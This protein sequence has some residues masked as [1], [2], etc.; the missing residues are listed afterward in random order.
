MKSSLGQNKVVGIVKKRYCKLPNQ[1]R[2]NFGKTKRERVLRGFDMRG[3]VWHSLRQ[4]NLLY[5]PNLS[6]IP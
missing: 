6:S 4:Q 5:L 3:A 2:A 1:A